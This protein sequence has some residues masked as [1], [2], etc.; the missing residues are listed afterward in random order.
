MGGDG[1]EEELLASGSQLVIASTRSRRAFDVVLPFPRPD[2]IDPS[3][4][5][6]PFQFTSFSRPRNNHQV[7]IRADKTHIT[8][9]N[10]MEPILIWCSKLGCIFLLYFSVYID[11]LHRK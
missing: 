1:E 10:T 9:A 8:H 5:W 6:I 7:T 4:R 3:L 2:S 11:L